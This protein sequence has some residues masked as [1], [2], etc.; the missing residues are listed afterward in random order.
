MFETDVSCVLSCDGRGL[1]INSRESY[2]SVTHDSSPYLT[3][4]RRM[5][6]FNLKGLKTNPQFESCIRSNCMS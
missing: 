5:Q 3:P 1:V 2:G 6:V 4:K